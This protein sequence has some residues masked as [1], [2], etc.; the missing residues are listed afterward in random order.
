MVNFNYKETYV[1][2]ILLKDDISIFH[3]DLNDEEDFSKKLRILKHYFVSLDILRD[4]FRHFAFI[5][6]N[7]E[8][9][10]S[11]FVEMK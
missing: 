10:I 3:Q 11:K 9:L 5:I 2:V 7:E 4:S 6:K 8:E 1:R